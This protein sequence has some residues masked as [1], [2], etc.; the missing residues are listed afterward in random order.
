MANTNETITKELNEISDFVKV[1]PII[2]DTIKMYKFIPMNML[3][4]TYEYSEDVVA[5]LKNNE[6]FKNR[7]WEFENYYTEKFKVPIIQMDDVLKYYDKI[8]FID[9]R[10]QQEYESLKIKDSLYLGLQKNKYQDV[11]NNSLDK[12]NSNKFIVLIGNKNSTY[13]DHISHLLNKKIKFVC[14]LQGGIDILELEEPN[15]L[16][17]K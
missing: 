8:L 1:D 15:L 9:I 3:P 5:E 17:K 11:T 7:W 14:I 6:F 2:N 4:I 10:T 13:I 16:I 12:H